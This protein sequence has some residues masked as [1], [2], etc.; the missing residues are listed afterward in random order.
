[1]QRSKHQ[2]QNK[3]NA[4]VCDNCFQQI[5][6]P[7]PRLTVDSPRADCCSMKCVEEWANLSEPERARRRE[8]ARKDS[9]AI[10]TD[11]KARR[12]MC[13][14]PPVTAL[15]RVRLP[16]PDMVHIEN[17]SDLIGVDIIGKKKVWY[18]EVK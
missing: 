7:M 2:E 14:L 18:R 13:L 4:V 9:V 16:D 8:Q 6:P 11:L 15:K 1:M 12:I 5:V 3:I 17:S 10:V